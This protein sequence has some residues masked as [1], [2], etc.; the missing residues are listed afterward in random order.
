MASFDRFIYS[1][2]KYLL[3]SVYVLQTTLSAEPVEVNKATGVKKGFLEAMTAESPQKWA[4]L[5]IGE[6]LKD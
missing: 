6:R 3:S 5:S 4:G 1:F 2:N